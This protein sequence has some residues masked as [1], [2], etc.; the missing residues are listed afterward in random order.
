M[1]PLSQDKI[2][3]R[4][5]LCTSCSV[6]LVASASGIFWTNLFK[7][8][9]KSHSNIQMHS[10]FCFSRNVISM[11]RKYATGAN[12]YT[13]R[14]FLRPGILLHSSSIS[15]PLQRLRKFR[16]LCAEL[17]GH[18][19]NEMST[20]PQGC[21]PGPLKSLKSNLWQVEQMFLSLQ[22]YNKSIGC[23]R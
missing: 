18:S 15:R 4:K 23:F 7:V 2:Q 3:K 6:I 13:S 12:S 11:H 21:P 9:T 8:K 19:S 20:Y 10:F 17:S 1:N 22:N 14:L 5:N 16:S